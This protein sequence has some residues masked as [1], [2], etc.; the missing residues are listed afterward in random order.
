VNE[1]AHVLI[2]ARDEAHTIGAV[3]RGC[4]AA[5]FA[6]T[7]IDD[8]SRDATA[9]L[10]R[11]AG[12]GVI[13]ARGTL[14]GKTAALR[15]ALRTV[16][17]E[18]PWLFFLDGDGQHDPADLPRFWAER[19]DADLVV[20]NRLPDAARMPLLRRW[21]NRAMS[22]LLAPS[23][24]ADSQCGFRLVRRAWLGD[25]LPAGHHFQF[26]SELALRAAARPTRVRNVPIAA[27]YADEESRIAP[28]RDG[29]NF[30]RCLCRPGS[31]QP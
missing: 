24:V 11:Q 3:V 7:V 5:G 1:A 17:A 19:A 9:H 26:E 10:A 18:V 14:H 13:T 27:T 4:R 20:G 23:G 8:G 25:W 29:L 16:P 6:V 15:L 12:A 2:P 28:W 31:H 22:A 21:T 30:A